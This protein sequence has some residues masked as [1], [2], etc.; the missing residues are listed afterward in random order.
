MP[1]AQRGQVFRR[2][3]RSW[4]IRY[5][6]DR[7]VRHEVAGHRTKGEANEALTSALDAARLGPVSRR[8]LTVKELVD[9]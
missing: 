3:G 1:S 9:E 5:Y 7:G 2:P 4:A 6:D 8:D